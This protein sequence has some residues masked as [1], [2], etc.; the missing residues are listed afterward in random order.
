MAQ[1]WRPSA[2]LFGWLSVAYLGQTAFALGQ[3]LSFATGQ[4]ARVPKLALRNCLWQR[5]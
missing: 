3:N 4:G 5:H 2:P 1:Q